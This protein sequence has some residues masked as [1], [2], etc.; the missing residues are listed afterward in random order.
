MQRGCQ[1]FESPRLH[2]KRSLACKSG[3]AAILP[4]SPTPGARSALELRRL[5]GYACYVN[6]RSLNGAI[7]V[8]R[9]SK[10]FPQTT[11]LW[12]MLFQPQGR[13]PA[14]R[15]VSFSVARTEVVGLLGAN[16]AGKTTLLQLLAGFG[17][18]EEGAVRV[19]GTITYCG[20]IERSF[21][22]RLSCRE[23][24][25]FFG[26]LAGV[27]ARELDAAIARACRIVDLDADLDRPFAAFSTGMRQRLALARALL[28]PADILLLDEPTRA[29][30][31]SHAHLIRSFIR[32]TLAGERGT[33]VVVATN[34]LEEAWEICDR[35]VILAHGQ[36][37]A[38]GDPRLLC[39]SASAAPA[40]FAEL[41]GTAG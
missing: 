38:A 19:N 24:L 9:V 8:D 10:S 21:Y 2:S 27:P 12:R 39:R 40:W 32:K 28:A 33:T 17:I 25:R 31:P 22:Y 18:P 30:D 7:V 13:R 34:S 11:S 16:G 4:Q 23:N 6:A 37:V 5:S 36:V 3:A 20:A 41:T 35:V 14:L 15:R 29:V 1:E 26:A